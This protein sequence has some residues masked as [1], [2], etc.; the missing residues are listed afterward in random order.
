MSLRFR[1]ILDGALAL[2]YI[3]AEDRG[4]ETPRR[5]HLHNHVTSADW[6]PYLPVSIIE[7]FTRIKSGAMCGTVAQILVFFLVLPEDIL[8]ASMW[9]NT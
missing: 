4:L 6:L 9:Q 2:Q 3:C 7:A 5:M 8:K 1:G